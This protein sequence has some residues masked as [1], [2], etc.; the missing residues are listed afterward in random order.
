MVYIAGF[1][2][3]ELPFTHKIKGILAIYGNDLHVSRRTPLFYSK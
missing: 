2:D 3:M 1:P